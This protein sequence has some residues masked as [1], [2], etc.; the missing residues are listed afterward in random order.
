MPGCRFFH[1]ESDWE[2]AMRAVASAPKTA[3]MH[4]RLFPNRDI[5]REKASL[6]VCFAALTWF[7][8]SNIPDVSFR[9]PPRSPGSRTRDPR[10]RPHTE[11]DEEG[12]AARR[13]SGQLVGTEGIGPGRAR[14]PPVARRSRSK[15][16]GPVPRDVART[17]RW[18]PPTRASPPALPGGAS[19]PAKL[20]LN[21]GA[22]DRPLLTAIWIGQDTSSAPFNFD[23]PCVVRVRVC[24]SVQARDELQGHVSPLLVGEAQG[25]AQDLLR[26]A[27]HA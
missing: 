27:A 21:F 19:R 15:T 7:A 11:S 10:T 25:F 20:R 12:R 8:P 14:R 23:D 4:R 17:T 18:R 5:R 24:R 3:P 22:N 2:R 1:V 6:R 9:A 26:S 16:R 13:A